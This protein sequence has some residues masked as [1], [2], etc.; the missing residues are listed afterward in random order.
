MNGD[1]III[2]VKV[3]KTTE[4]LQIKRDFMPTT[5]IMFFSHSDSA[6]SPKIR[7]AFFPPETSIAQIGMDFKSYSYKDNTIRVHDSA[8]QERMGVVR[9]NGARVLLMAINDETEL[10]AKSEQLADIADRYPGQYAV[11]IARGPSLNYLSDDDICGCFPDS[12]YVQLL[13]CDFNQDYRI[14]Q[15]ELIALCLTAVD[16]FD[17]N[18]LTANIQN[19]ASRYTMMD[20]MPIAIALV[21]GDDDD[22]I[23]T[24][25]YAPAQE[26]GAIASQGATGAVLAELTDLPEAHEI[27]T[28]PRQ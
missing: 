25:A 26:I 7:Q 27:Y 15:T 5:K 2:S 23:L 1:I 19:S 24:A 17:N 11:C 20:E 13:N 12:M 18:V 10:S 14:L 16:T 3:N 22:S 8:R 21:D 28:P 6:I 9:P 4:R